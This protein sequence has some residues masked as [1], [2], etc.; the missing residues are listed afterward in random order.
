MATHC[1]LCGKPAS[2]EYAQQN[3]NDRRV[4]CRRCGMY[5][6]HVSAWSSYER[7]DVAPVDRHLLSAATRTA[8]VRGL[9]PLR[10]DRASFAALRDGEIREPTFLERRDALMNWLAYESRRDPKSAYGARVKLDPQNDYP[11][12]YCHSLD[13]GNADE[14]NFVFQ[15]LMRDGLIEAEGNGGVRI[16]DKGWDLLETRPQAS[17]ELGFIAMA[18]K[19]T[20]DV[21]DAIE[22]GIALAGYKPL[23]IDGDH[24]IG[25]VM[26]RILAKIRESRFVVADFTGNRGGVYYEAGFALGLNI[27]VFTLCRHDC[28]DGEEA[29]RV[30]FD[31]RHLNNLTWELQ[32]LGKLTEDLAARLVAVL[33]PGPLPPGAS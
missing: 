8:P 2:V 20:D 23:R 28:L 29:V 14:W 18:F 5:E 21:R 17:G 25:G 7:M 3:T 12:A 13:D 15:P 1:R 24:Y 9:A 10:I 4:I 27:P 11:V 33:G 6:A 32:N 31:V 22:K 19:D 16:T 26:D 30:H